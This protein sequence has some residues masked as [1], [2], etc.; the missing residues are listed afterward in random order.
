MKQ[1]F[2]ILMMVIVFTGCVKKTPEL[3]SP[4]VSADNGVVENP[5]GERTPINTWLNATAKA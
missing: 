1:V 3:K 4:C 2:V 5:C